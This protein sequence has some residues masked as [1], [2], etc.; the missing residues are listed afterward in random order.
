[1]ESERFDRL[2]RL[3]SRSGSRRSALSGLAKAA[4]GG[5][6]GL[7]GA[8]A[9]SR[10]DAAIGKKKRECNGDAQC[11]EP[12]NPCQRGVCKRGKCRKKRER[13]GKTCG[14]GLQ[15]QNGRCICPNG[16]CVQTVRPSNMRGWQFYNDQIDQPIDPTMESGPETPPLGSGSA[17]LQIGGSSEGKLISSNILMDTPLSEFETLEYSY[18]VTDSSGT[19]PSFQMGI[20][21][22]L[23][24]NEEGFQGRMVYVPSA[25][26]AVTEGD[27][28]TVDLLADNGTGNWF[29]TCATAR[30]VCRANS[31]GLC[32]QADF[33]NFSEIVA[34]FPNIGIHSVGEEG[35]GAGFGLIGMKV[36]SGE[37]AVD[38]NVDAVRIKLEGAG[39]NTVVYNFEPDPQ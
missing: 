19:G 7:A 1:M 33:C 24:D 14:D 32:T 12:N 39:Q 28:V 37:G 13:A 38:A 21:F 4:V 25:Q 20:D 6:L 22:D 8:S 27:W 34:A 31:G 5:A 2:A 35:T 3:V 18:Y 30:P 26:G 36:G 9:V 11:P 23:T 17:L 10:D 29:F 15:C 16:V